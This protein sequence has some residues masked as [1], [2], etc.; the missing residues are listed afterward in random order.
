MAPVEVPAS[1]PSAKQ[2]AEVLVMQPLSGY[3]VGARK[4][5][6]PAHEGSDSAMRTKVAGQSATLGDID[7]PRGHPAEQQA[8][9]LMKQPSPG[10]A[11]G[12][13]RSPP[14]GHGGS[15]S[16]LRA[17][18]SLSATQREIDSPRRSMTPFSPFQ[19]LAGSEDCFDERFPLEE[20]MD[21]VKTIRQAFKEEKSAWERNGRQPCTMPDCKSR[22]H[23]PPCW[24]TPEGK[25]RL[26]FIKRARKLDRQWR[27]T[28]KTA[29][30]LALEPKSKGKGKKKGKYRT[31]FN[32]AKTHDVSQGCKMPDC[33]RSPSCGLAHPDWES[34]LVAKQR[35]EQAGLLSKE[36]GRSGLSEA[37]F[38][39]MLVLWKHVSPGQMTEIMAAMKQKRE[40]EEAPEGKSNKSA[41]KGKLTKG[42]PLERKRKARSDDHGFEDATKADASDSEPSSKRHKEF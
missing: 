9:V 11:A 8:E 15:D 1:G 16:A 28:R 36:R 27:A 3:E 40:Q 10:L 34:C 19:P 33:K 35:F 31:C 26:G 12:V 7:S 18:A 24:S 29:E 37:D 39:K 2:Q 13:R 30:D 25:E 23:A 42:K 17:V 32:C 4:Y 14:L 38:D 41:P 22:E 5:S 21:R 20:R 6:P